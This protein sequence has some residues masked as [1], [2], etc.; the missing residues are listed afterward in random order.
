MSVGVGQMFESICLFVRLSVCLEHNSKTND[1]KV[2]KHGTIGNTLGHPRSGTVLE[3]K[4]Q[5]SRSQGH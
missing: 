5:R 3:F 4:G 1:P 2:F